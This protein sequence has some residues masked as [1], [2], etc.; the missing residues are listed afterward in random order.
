MLIR[1]LYRKVFAVPGARAVGG[2]TIEDTFRRFYAHYKSEIA[3][4]SA[5]LDMHGKGEATGQNYG[6]MSRRFAEELV[7]PLEMLSRSDSIS[8]EKAVPDSVARADFGAS[9]S[10]FRVAADAKPEFARIDI[11]GGYSSAAIT[12]SSAQFP[13]CAVDRLDVNSA[14]AVDTFVTRYLEFNRPVILHS[15]EAADQVTEQQYRV[16]DE[17]RFDRLLRPHRK[18]KSRKVRVCVNCF[19]VCSLVYYV[20]LLLLVIL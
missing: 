19:G 15:S 12:A 17:W 6:E 7:G 5:L 2:A 4:L 9:N 13:R 20:V 10:V 16:V 14:G 8:L 18:L 11:A 1:V 3:E